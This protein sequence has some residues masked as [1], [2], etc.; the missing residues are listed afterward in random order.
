MYSIELAIHNRILK[1]VS[2]NYSSTNVFDIDN[3]RRISEGS[4]DTD[5]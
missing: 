1:K 5:D 3:N 4:C 2:K